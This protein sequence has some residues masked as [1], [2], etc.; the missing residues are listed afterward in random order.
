MTC[1]HPQTLWLRTK[2][3]INFNNLREQDQ[4]YWNKATF[5][6]KGFPYQEYYPIEVPCGK[7]LGC[8]LDHA[9]MW[10]TRITLEARNWAHNW[11]ITLTYNEPNLPKNK[12]LCKRDVQNF[13]KRL[14]WQEKGERDWVNPKNKKLENPIRYFYCGEYGPK[15]GRPHYHMALFNLGLQFS[16]LKFY[17]QNKWGDNLYQCPKLQKLW[18]KGF[19]VVGMLTQKS[20]NYIARYVQKK[21]GIASKPR[22]YEYDN[23]KCTR[24]I[25]KYKQKQPEFVNMSTSVGLGAKWWEDNKEFLKRYQHII[26]KTDEKI[27]LKPL[28]RY[29]KK[30]W[31]KEDW[32]GYEF[33]KYE[34]IKKG[35]ERKKEIL[36]TENWENIKSDIDAWKKH[37]EKEENLLKSKAKILRRD[38]FI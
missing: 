37:L 16:D 30:L 27:K 15:N 14:R 11:F 7:C 20:A 34:N 21:A 32:E 12:E 23:Q 6:P 8:R 17:K 9:D 38:N 10:A 4:K 2:R 24:K 36:S 1:F 29:F 5:K 25:K 18:G 33:A 22:I 13:L 19:V 31:A 3:P 28:P 26:I 35:I